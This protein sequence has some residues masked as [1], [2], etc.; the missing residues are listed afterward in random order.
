MSNPQPSFEGVTPTGTFL[1]ERE[2]FDLMWIASWKATQAC[3]AQGDGRADKVTKASAFAA[4]EAVYREHR[5][6]DFVAPVIPLPPVP[7]EVRERMER[8]RLI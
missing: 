6:Q 2:L 1:T 7:D 5:P 4:A 3:E 8:E